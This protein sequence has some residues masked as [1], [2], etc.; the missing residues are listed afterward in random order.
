MKAPDFMFWLDRHMRFL[1][2][3]N[4]ALPTGSCG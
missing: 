3:L 4:L 2:G 1:S